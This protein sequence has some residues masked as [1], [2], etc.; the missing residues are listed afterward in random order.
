M[1]MKLPSRWKLA[2]ALI[3]A[4]LYDMAEVAADGFYDDFASPLPM[5]IHQLVADLRK[6]GTPEAMIV[7]QDAINGEFDATDEEAERW[8]MSPEGKDSMAKL[9]LRKRDS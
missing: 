7:A 5:P 1:A 3:A 9:L 6:V 8:A 2:C 4:G